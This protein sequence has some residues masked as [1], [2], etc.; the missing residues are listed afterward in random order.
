M[1]IQL[2]RAYDKPSVADGARVLVDRLWPRGVTK[3]RAAIDEWLKDLAPSDSLRKWAHANALA[4][5]AFRKRYLKELSEPAASKALERLYDMARRRKTVTLV[6]SSRGLGG[7]PERTNAGILK[8][9]LEG[10]RKPPTSSGPAKA[11]AVPM[12]AQRR[13]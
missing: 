11:A 9:L 7:D 3:Q 12:R 13:K 2:K 10:M 5:N 1:S 4:W 8:E 6:Y